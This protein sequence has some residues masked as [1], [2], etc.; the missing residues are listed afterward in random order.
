MLWIN[1]LRYERPVTTE[2]SFQKRLKAHTAVDA[3]TRRSPS[4]Q[5][6]II[7][8]ELLV[9][10]ESLIQVRS[11]KSLV[12]GNALRRDGK[13]KTAKILSVYALDTEMKHK[14][15]SIKC[16]RKKI[17]RSQHKI[18]SEGKIVT[19]NSTKGQ[20]FIQ[21]SHLPRATKR[22]TWLYGNF[23]RNIMVLNKIEVRKSS[24]FSFLFNKSLPLL[25][26]DR[27]F[28]VFR[29]EES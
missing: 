2:L 25:C 29:N 8:A 6:R 10:R 11:L 21:A 4:T 27:Y 5:K 23:V 26:I 18:I 9:Y 7:N 28:L 22:S 13:R 3:A 1:S 24:L 12:W 19:A 16:Q 15:L 14:Q 17:V 20:G